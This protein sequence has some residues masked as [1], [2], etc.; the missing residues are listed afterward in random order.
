MLFINKIGEL[1]GINMSKIGKMLAEWN[2]LNIIQGQ[3]DWLKETGDHPDKTDDQLFQMASEDPD[4]FSIQWEY[5]CDYL[6]E[7]ME[8]N[9]HGGWMAEVK[10]FGWR[11][12]NGHK[13]FEARTGRVLL[14]KILPK[15]ECTFKVYRYGKGLAIN[16]AHHDSPTWN[17]WYYITPCKKALEMAA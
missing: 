17:E 11:S 14:Q 9:S 12:L 15:T 6:T 10:N 1:E 8:K 4:L 2:T 13:Y 16:N 7:L 5:L 3:V